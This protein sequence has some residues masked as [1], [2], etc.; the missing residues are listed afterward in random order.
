MGHPLP[1]DL[2]GML[3]EIEQAREGVME[4]RRSAARPRTPAPEDAQRRLLSALELYAGVVAARGWPLPHELRS[5]LEL[6][7]SLFPRL[8]G[9]RHGP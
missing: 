3:L 7:R 9:T 8:R 6:Y 5:E 2:A 4:A 1:S